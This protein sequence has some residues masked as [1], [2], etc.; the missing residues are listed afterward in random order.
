MTKE[1]KFNYAKDI[2]KPI[3]DKG[4]VIGHN[5]VRIYYDNNDKPIGEK[6][7]IYVPKKK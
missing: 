4:K 6:I 1:T 3:K 5:V 7:I 2:N